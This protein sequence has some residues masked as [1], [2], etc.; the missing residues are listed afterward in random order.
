MGLNKLTSFYK[1]QIA[2]KTKDVTLKDCVNTINCGFDKVLHKNAFVIK[3]PKIG[4][5]KKT[6]YRGTDSINT[7]FFEN[8]NKSS[9][10]VSFHEAI[11]NIVEWSSDLKMLASSFNNF[12]WTRIIENDEPIME[13]NDAFFTQLFNAVSGKKSCYAKYFDEFAIQHKIGYYLPWLS[14]TAQIICHVKNEMATVTKNNIAINFKNRLLSTLR[15]RL[16]DTLS[17]DKSFSKLTTKWK[18]CLQ[19]L[20]DHAYDYLI[21]SSNLSEEIEQV[22]SKYNINVDPSNIIALLQD[23][24]TMFDAMLQDNCNSRKNILKKKKKT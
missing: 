5:L 23:D 20:V 3:N 4:A 16:L 19:E 6:I 10:I 12:L 8:Y 17:C 22:N 15:W 14:N 21:N 7:D 11:S 13:I 2:S 1:D 9:N 18:C 24:V